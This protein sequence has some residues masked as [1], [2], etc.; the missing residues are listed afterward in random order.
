MGRLRK[1]WDRIVNG[2]GEELGEAEERVGGPLYALS[3][4]A[5]DVEAG[6]LARGSWPSQAA[7]TSLWVRGFRTVVN[8]CAE[9]VQD[10]DVLRAGMAPVNIPVRDNTVPTELQVQVF[11]NA[12]ARGRPV[13]VHCEAGKGRTG[14]MIAAYRVLVQ[15]WTPERA[16]AE[17]K[18][19]GLGMPC[20]RDWILALQ[21][22]A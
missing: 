13:Y 2:A 19:F 22:N 3:A 8:L 15:H 10:L 14:C 1:L 11:L 18:A 9:R 12:V 17:A 21:E 5:A 16:L 7:L 4:Y 6:V 20:Q